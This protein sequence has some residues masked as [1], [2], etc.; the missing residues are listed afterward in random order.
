[1]IDEAAQL[2]MKAEACRRLAE[3]SDDFAREALWL[4]RADHWEQ[5]ATEAAKAQGRRAVPKKARDPI[6][7]KF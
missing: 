1:M 4:R 3:L 7:R 5:L 2:R 6:K